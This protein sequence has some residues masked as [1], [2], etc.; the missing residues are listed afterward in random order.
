MINILYSFLACIPLRHSVCLD[1]LY[2]SLKYNPYT[3]GRS[4]WHSKLCGLHYQLIMLLTHRQWANCLQYRLLTQ[5]GNVL[6]LSYLTIYWQ[7]DSSLKL[8]ETE[9]CCPLKEFDSFSG[10]HFPLKHARTNSVFQLWSKIRWFLFVIQVSE[11]YSNNILLYI[12]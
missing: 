3:W 6:F 11:C 2:M 8:S 10:Q 1:I 4:F 9:C 7:V 12:R 5:H